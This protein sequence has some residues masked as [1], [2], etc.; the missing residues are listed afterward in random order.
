MEPIIRKATE[1]DMEAIH[2]LVREL[3]DYEK[4]LH[5]VTT[6]AESYLRDF[7]EKVFDAFV[8]EVDGDIVGMALYYMNFSTWKGKMMYLEDFIV[9]ESMRGHGIGALLFDAFLEESR[10]QGAVM[11]KWQVLKWN[12][13][14]IHFYKKYQTVLDDEWYDGKI[15]FK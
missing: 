9:K 10:R 8:A 1:D 6:T 4:G 7:R 12:E 15:Y 13:P 14:A 2:A 11:V 5:R 3:A